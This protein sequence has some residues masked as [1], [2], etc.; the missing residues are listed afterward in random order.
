MA[1]FAQKADEVS[2]VDSIGSLNSNTTNSEIS[3]SNDSL[4]ANEITIFE[5][6]AKAFINAFNIFVLNIMSSVKRPK[7]DSNS[8]DDSSTP[9]KTEFTNLKQKVDELNLIIGLYNTLIQ[10]A[11][12][13]NKIDELTGLIGKIDGMIR[14]RPKLIDSFS[15]FII[16]A[17]HSQ[18]LQRSF[19]RQKL[20][21]IDN[22]V[23]RLMIEYSGI[24][25]PQLRKELNNQAFQK[26]LAKFVRAMGLLDNMKHRLNLKLMILKRN[27]PADTNPAIQLL[28]AAVTI[29]DALKRFVDEPAIAFGPN[30][31]SDEALQALQ[32]IRNEAIQTVN[33]LTGYNNTT[34][35]SQ[36]IN[37]QP[38]SQDSIV[39]DITNEG[40][41]DQHG[42]ID[43]VSN[44]L[45]QL[46]S[47]LK[48]KMG[49]LPNTSETLTE[50]EKQLT[51]EEKQLA[52]AEIQLAVKEIDEIINENQPPSDATGGKS[53]RQK[54][55]V[56]WSTPRRHRNSRVKSMKPKK[57]QNRRKT[58][59]AHKKRATK[60][61]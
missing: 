11:I 32:N 17:P 41:Q 8:A 48:Q 43:P 50:E 57:I 27:K 22:T 28:S 31:H 14:E 7:L 23:V 58:K 40:T 53:H 35:P 39:S 30:L 9:T 44:Q 16:I 36:K 29:D 56:K 49:E 6:I 54:R 26:T 19:I 42:D 38:S 18:I 1:L 47:S 15:K 25:E 52:E 33:K 34:P 10:N 13:Q 3:S 12:R 24:N 5:A 59:S 21:D 45:M 46:L 37:D 20:L 55:R 60:K 2:L 61:H 51:E 4:L